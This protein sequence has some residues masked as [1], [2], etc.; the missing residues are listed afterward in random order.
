MFTFAQQQTNNYQKQQNKTTKDPTTNSANLYRRIDD[1]M[2]NQA[3]LN[4][5]QKRRR[6]KASETVADNALINEASELVNHDHVAFA[7]ALLSPR[8][9]P[10][11]PH[12]TAD[13]NDRAEPRR[14]SYR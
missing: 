2:L 3:D 1:V 9:I 12:S 8:K 11:Q 10:G 13:P 4:H 7:Q 14:S 6:S 5:T